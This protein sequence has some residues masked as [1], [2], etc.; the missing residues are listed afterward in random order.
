MKRLSRIKRDDRSYHGRPKRD[1]IRL[2][3]VKRELATKKGQ[4]I[5]IQSIVPATLTWGLLIWYNKRMK[6]LLS[7]RLNRQDQDIMNIIELAR[8]ERSFTRRVKVYAEIW[9][10]NKLIKQPTF[11]A[12]VRAN[13]NS[14]LISFGP[15]ATRLFK[16]NTNQRCVKQ[17]I[18]MVSRCPLK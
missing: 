4:V 13:I 11:L 10:M 12:F 5:F 2:K 6:Q 16:L 7:R 1:R 14:W 9:V 8:I 18:H 15:R 3:N 17:Q